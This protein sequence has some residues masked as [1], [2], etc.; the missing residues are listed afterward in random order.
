ME[1][2]KCNENPIRRVKIGVVGVDSGQLIVCDPCYLKDQKSLTDYEGICALPNSKFKQLL[3][4]L[5]HPGAGVAFDTGIGDGIY[6]VWAE[7][8]DAGDGW[9]ERIRKVEIIF[10]P[11][12]LG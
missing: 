1:T 7:I 10:L 12:V 8:G 4:N 2:E 3:Y 9:G 11:P 6:E 5:G